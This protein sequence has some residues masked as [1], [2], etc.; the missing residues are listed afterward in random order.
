[1]SA[2]P[3]CW[4]ASV[5]LILCLPGSSEAGPTNSLFNPTDYTVLADD[6]T[7]TNGTLVVDTK[8]GVTSPT[9]TTN[10]VLAYTGRIVTN[11]SGAVVMALFS[12]GDFA[13]S[14]GVSCTVTGNL[15]LVLSCTGNMTIAGTI[16]LSGQNGTT[17]AGGPGGPGG[18]AGPGGGFKSAPPDANHG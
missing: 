6:L 16:D 2:K 18:E 9:I 4:A 15:G 17:S 3:V 7:L 12:F 14:T 11:Q 8:N 10:D 13:V 5:M 1:M